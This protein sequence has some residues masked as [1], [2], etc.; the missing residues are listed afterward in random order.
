MRSLRPL[1]ATL[2]ATLAAALIFGFWPGLDLVVA[3]ALHG[4]EGFI[5]RTPFTGTLRS[6][7]FVIP[8]LCLAAAGVAWAAGRA[9]WIAPI[10]GRAILLLVATL[11]AG[12]GLL[13]NL[14][15]KEHSGRPRPSQ[16]VEFG[17]TAEFRPFGRF[18]GACA[19]NCS[20]VSGEA[21]AAAWT[22]A[23]ALLVP[24]PAR[25]VAV[26]S[27]LVFTAAVSALRLSFGGHFLSDVAFAALFTW[28]IVLAAARGFGPGVART[29]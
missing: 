16:I 29:S 3:R 7:F 26:A 24:P 15:L 23:P 12:P 28:L 11:A 25:G 18:D 9:G 27:A 13:V 14:G 6:L 4:P 20:F 2:A 5:G 21:S 8:Y 19:K 10:P 17:G 1:A 22:L